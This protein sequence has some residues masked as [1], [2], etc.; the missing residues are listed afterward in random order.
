VDVDVG[1]GVELEDVRVVVVVVNFAGP[2]GLSDS[3][4]FDEVVEVEEYD[5]VLVDD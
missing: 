5:E 1:T 4:D 3:G 2:P